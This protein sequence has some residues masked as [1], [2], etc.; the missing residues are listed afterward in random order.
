MRTKGFTLIELLVVVAI[1]GLLGAVVV[2]GMTNAR[3]NAQDTSVKQQM[4][5]LRTILS[6]EFGDTGSY[7]NIK[8]GG[9]WWASGASCTQS[10]FTGTYA[11]QA[12]QICD[13]LVKA[14]GTGCASNCV[15]FRTTNPT[16]NDRYSIMAY[17]PGASKRAGS[18]RYLC[19]GSSGKTNVS[20]GLTW[21][22]EGCYQNP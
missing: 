12:K 3:L 18:A 22:E 5:Q 2:A 4:A 16:G 15:Y 8:T 7:A 19:M 17:L 1:I 10:Q 11:N 21:T 14:A 6:Q 13:A 20:T 9:G